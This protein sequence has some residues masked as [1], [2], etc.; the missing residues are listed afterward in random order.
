VAT[1]VG[2]LIDPDPVQPREPVVDRVDVGP[3]PGQDR[4]HRAPSD[5]HQLGDRRLRA[6]RGQPGHLLVEHVGMTGAVARPGELSH[7]DAVDRAVH[8]WRV[9]LEKH[10]DR[11]QVEPSPASAPVPLVVPRRPTAARAAASLA[12]PSRPDMSH[13]HGRVLVVLH[14]LDDG[15]LDAQQGAP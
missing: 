5:P 14:V 9:G 13:D 4:S 10:L 2:D 12:G 15:V 7:R 1:L 8:P 3:D 6:L 11:A